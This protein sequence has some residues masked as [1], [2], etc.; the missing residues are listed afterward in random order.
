MLFIWLS[1]ACEKVLFP[2]IIDEFF[3]TILIYAQER[4]WIQAMPGSPHSDTGTIKWEDCSMQLLFRL[5]FLFIALSILTVVVAVCPLS[6]LPAYHMVMD[7]RRLSEK[8]FLILTKSKHLLSIFYVIA[9]MIQQV[10]QNGKCPLGHIPQRVWIAKQKKQAALS[11]TC[12]QYG[13]FTISSLS[14]KVN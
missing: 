6:R 2:V 12:S 7:S 14:L 13:A 5:C 4:I 1:S 3:I 9:F 11:V 10:K 8:K